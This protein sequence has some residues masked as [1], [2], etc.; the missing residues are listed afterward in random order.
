MISLRDFAIRDVTFGSLPIANTNQGYYSEPSEKS[1]V[2]F[3]K[4]KNFSVDKAEDI[5]K[6]V[7]ERVSQ[8]NDWIYSEKNQLLKKFCLFKISALENF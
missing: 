6:L 1:M 7:N 8:Y 4:R 2:E 5:R 3:F